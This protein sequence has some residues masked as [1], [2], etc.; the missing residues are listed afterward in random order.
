[1]RVEERKRS[2][3]RTE[4]LEI[5]GKRVVVSRFPGPSD[6]WADATPAE[7]IFIVIF[8]IV[9]SLISGVMK[10]YDLHVGGIASEQQLRLGSLAVEAEQTGPQRNY[11]LEAFDVIRDEAARQD[12]R[13]KAVDVQE[14]STPERYPTFYPGIRDTRIGF[15]DGGK[16][17]LFFHICLAMGANMNGSVDGQ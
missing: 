7:K 12:P 4:L 15:I 5:N 17:Q 16:F 9:L 8:V 13:I 14:E 3:F 1:M 11:S 6:N 10:H 2:E